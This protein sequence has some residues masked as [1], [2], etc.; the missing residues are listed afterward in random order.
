MYIIKSK[1][2]KNIHI[3]D[4]GIRLIGT[5]TVGIK[6]NE[7]LLEHS[8][9]IHLV[10]DDLI[11]ESDGINKTG[12]KNIVNS[13]EELEKLPDLFPGESAI[14]IQKDEAGNVLAT[15]EYI[16]DD[17]N[18]S[19]IALNSGGEGGA[20][21][22]IH[23][24]SHPASMIIESDEKQFVSKQQKEIWD[25]KADK[26]FV[27]NELNNKVNKN[28]LSIYALKSEIP[29][30]SG[31]AD[32]EN[33]YTKQEID[34]KIAGLTPGGDIGPHDHNNLYY[35]KSETY[36]KNE[37]DQKLNL[38]VNSTELEKYA[39]KENIPDVSDKATIEYVNTQLNLKANANNVYTKS[40]VDNLIDTIPNE[41]P[42]YDVSQAG[43]VL[44]VN[45]LGTLE[46]QSKNAASKVSPIST[47][48]VTVDNSTAKFLVKSFG[49]G[50]TITKTDKAMY[51]V[52]I[53]DGVEIKSLYINFDLREIQSNGMLEFKWEKAGNTRVETPIYKVYNVSNNGIESSNIISKLSPMTGSFDP[54]YYT[55][56]NITSGVNLF[57]TLIW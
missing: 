48:S 26:N 51:T 38:K 54:N 14:L 10:K 2:G 16:W 34:E 36:N 45:N 8:K 3:K 31:K 7:Y 19:W 46:W 53:P 13:I 18:K 50:I 25:A 11:I 49:E 40:E 39:L 47:Y 41:L 20:P 4:L 12:T 17:N 52:N 6:V 29:D 23:P 44:G 42:A 55:L 35:P 43:Q 1:N 57:V 27:I 33:V 15:A 24:S 56:T 21:P 22:Y 28:E 37:I 9:D 32:S 30:I 5:D